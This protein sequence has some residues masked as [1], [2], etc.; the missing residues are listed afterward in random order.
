MLEM[1]GDG[2]PV[3]IQDLRE[4]GI[5]APGQAMYEL[6]LSGCDVER[7]AHTDGTGHRLSAY[8]IGSRRMPAIANSP[9]SAA[10]DGH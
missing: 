5:E 3:T 10:H 8:R 9:A 7:V 6:Q 2:G 4:Q 1:L